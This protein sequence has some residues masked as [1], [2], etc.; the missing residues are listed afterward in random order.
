MDFTTNAIVWFD[1]GIFVISDPNI[2]IQISSKTISIKGLDKMCLLNGDIS[3]QLSSKLLITAGTPIDSAIKATVTTLG[4]ETKVL[5]E[6][7][8]YNTPYDIEKDVGTTV[9]D[10]VSELNNLYMD[11]QSFYD[12]KGYFVFNKI[13]NKLNDPIIWDFTD[14]DFRLSGNN[15]INYSNI[16]NNFIIYGKLLDSGVQ[17]VSSKELT[18]SNS[19][20]SP[21]NTTAMDK[22][23]WVVK[24]DRLFTQEQCDERLNY[25]IWKHTNFNEKISFSCVPIYFLSINDLIYINDVSSGII[26]TYCI[27]SITVPL[28]NSDSM[29]IGAYKIYA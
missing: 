13:R 26:G 5:I 25:E 22:R 23:T 12:T 6:T 27:N 9:W 2:D 3:G 8:D 29:N 19:P 10:V 14:K 7:H 11:W 4:L 15:Q 21:F 1:Y 18:I 17:I 16:R 24:D 28:K 20:T